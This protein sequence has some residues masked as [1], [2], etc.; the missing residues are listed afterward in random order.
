M[1]DEE[2]IRWAPKVSRTLVRHL[3]RRDA[4]GIVDDELIDEVGCALYNRCDSIR[5]VSTYRG[6]C[7]RCGAIF[8]AG[9]GRDPEAAI[10]CTSEGCGWATTAGVYRHSRAH[11]DLIGGNFM[12]E[13]EAFMAGFDAACDPRAK[14]RLIDQLIHAF[15]RGPA[16][17]PMKSAAC[18][19][20]D[21]PRKGAA[22][23]L[24]ALSYGEGNTPGLPETRA[25]WREKE[26]NARRA[27]RAFRDQPTYQE[28]RTMSKGEVQ[29]AVVTGGHSYDVINFHKLFRDLPGIAAYVQH[30]DDFASSRTEVREGYDVVLFYIMLRE[31]PTDEGLPS[32]M[33][34]P[35]TALESL[36]RTEQG[37]VML[38]HAILA[39]PQ[40]PAWGEMVG[41]ADSTLASYHHDERMNLHVADPAHPI[42]QGMSDWTLVDETYEMADAGP[43]SQVLLTTDHPQCMKTIAWTRTYGRSRVF[44]FECGHDNA[45]WPD[46]GF[47]QVL[48]N[49]IRWAAR[50]I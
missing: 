14:M 16:G 27:R 41:I 29:L 2:R 15:H 50:R 44:C 28:G 30:M 25:A 26:A 1:P 19:L 17:Q 18:S 42:T 8:E 34:K 6:R 38:H 10:S 49:G 20:I 39:Y 4:L 48:A 32:Y 33:G 35:R 3:Y 43:G 31:G 5:L 21:G 37:I 11:R 22:A 47:R 24:D 45:T 23:F 13:V 12:P 7:P 36:G 40:W 9:L 46:P